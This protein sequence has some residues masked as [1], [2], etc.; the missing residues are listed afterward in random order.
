MMSYNAATLVARVERDGPSPETIALAGEVIRRGGLVAFPTETVYGLGANALDAVAITH[1]FEAKQRPAN[2]PIIVHIA[3]PQ[4]LDQIAL[5][6]PTA[7]YDLAQ[8]FWPGPLTL[9]LMKRPAIP[10]NV[11]AG[12]QTVAIRLPDHPVARALL[13]NA[14]VPIGAPSANRFSRPSPTTAAH[15]LADLDGHVD[16]VLDAGSTRI[17]VEST[18]IDMTSDPPQVLRPGGVAIEALRAILP[19]VVY[20]PRYLPETVASAP[21]P[22]TLLKHYAPRAQVIVH[23]GPHDLVIHQLI[24]TARD[25]AKQG[26]RVGLLLPDADVNQFGALPVHVTPLGQ[27]ESAQA[28]N[29]YGALRD[30]DEAGVDVIL[31]A[32]PPE[33][34]LSTALRDRLMRAA[35]GQVIRVDAT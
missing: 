12:R 29:L 2:D 33:T 6:V 13:E 23:E 15:V 27:D 21:A 22:G 20:Q 1:I 26:R 19:D 5:E 10:D 18:I 4:Q 9:V 17:G 16:V 7:A 3:S 28:A 35:E 25:L 31:A 11:T 32:L 30:L 14:G 8:S 24:A 34:G